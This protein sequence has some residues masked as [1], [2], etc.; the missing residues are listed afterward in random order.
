MRVTGDDVQG[1]NLTLQ[2]GA[3]TTSVTV[4]GDAGSALQT[5][6]ANVDVQ[7]TA[8]RCDNCRKWAAIRMICYVSPRA[9]SGTGA[10]GQRAVGCSPQ[11]QRPGRIQ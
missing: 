2:P 4:Q 9:F 8:Q 5:E 1:A 11:W 3:M 7:L 6:N 10:V